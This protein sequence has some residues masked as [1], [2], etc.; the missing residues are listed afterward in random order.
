MVQ[1]KRLLQFY[2]GTGDTNIP[3]IIRMRF[4]ELELNVRIFLNRLDD[5]EYFLNNLIL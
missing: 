4:Y 1:Y 5:I 3:Y 2:F